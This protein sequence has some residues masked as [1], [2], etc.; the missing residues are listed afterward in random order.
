MEEFPLIVKELVESGEQK[1][2]YLLKHAKSSKKKLKK[3]DSVL[4]HIIDNPQE[5]EEKGKE[6][7][8]D[9]CMRKVGVWKNFKKEDTLHGADTKKVEAQESL[10]S[11]RQ[12]IEE[13]KSGE[14]D[15]DC[16]TRKVGAW[17]NFKTSGQVEENARV[18]SQAAK[19]SFHPKVKPK[20]SPKKAEIESSGDCCTRKVGTWKNF[21]ES[22]HVDI[23]PHFANPKEGIKSVAISDLPSSLKTNPT[24]P[25]RLKE[26]EDIFHQLNAKLTT[27]IEKFD[28]HL[29]LSKSIQENINPKGELLSQKEALQIRKPRKHNLKE[30][31]DFTTNKSIRSNEDTDL[32]FDLIFSESF[33]RNEKEKQEHYRN[34][35]KLKAFHIPKQSEKKGFEMMEQSYSSN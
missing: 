7:E 15:G 20:E 16:C 24:M 11:G 9:C 35:C 29:E 17:K 31:V 10:Q 12:P 3:Q 13:K 21:K 5:E 14:N 23:A 8:H 22:T 25:L 27:L 18:K 33:V 26:I 19:A 2:L 1:R 34:Q 4:K 28:K 32:D 30:K 6:E